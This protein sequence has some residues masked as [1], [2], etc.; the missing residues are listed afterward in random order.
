MQ[1]WPWFCTVARETLRVL[2]IQRLP[3]ILQEGV[4]WG[5]PDKD[6]AVRCIPGEVKCGALPHFFFSNSAPYKPPYSLKLLYHALLYSPE[7]HK[8]SDVCAFPKA[9]GKQSS[10]VSPLDVCTDSSS[11]YLLYSAFFIA[12]RADSAQ[13]IAVAWEASETWRAEAG[14]DIKVMSDRL[15]L[16]S[17]PF[18]TL[19]VQIQVGRDIHLA[20]ARPTAWCPQMG[21]DPFAEFQ[22]V[23]NHV[24]IDHDRSATQNSKSTFD[25]LLSYLFIVRETSKI[26][27]VIAVPS[28]FKGS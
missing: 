13:N 8:L 1:S 26:P 21:Q 4:S 2:H 17:L 10:T 27:T 11:T 15:H 16:P 7:A 12:S 23:R 28:H 9:Y 14:N 6:Y 25:L 24:D 22:F 3:P 5:K 19:T 18:L 20:P